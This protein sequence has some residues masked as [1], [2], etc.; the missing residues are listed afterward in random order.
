MTKAASELPPVF[1]ASWRTVFP[2]QFCRVGISR[3]QPR[4]QS[5]YI[6][7]PDLY[8][9]PWFRSVSEHEYIKRYDAILSSLDPVD[10]VRKL[11]VRSQGRPIALLCF[12]RADTE[13]GWCH[14]ALAARWLAAALGKPVPE[15]G[16]EHLPMDLHPTLPPSLL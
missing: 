7:C 9:G 12:E 6:L 8:P 10:V 13:D 15:F 11:A 5:G 2:P 14:R 3:G 4:G 1:T 16:F